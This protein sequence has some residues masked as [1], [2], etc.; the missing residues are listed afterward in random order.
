[1]TGVA[2]RVDGGLTQSVRSEGP[3]AAYAAAVA[4]SGAYEFSPARAAAAGAAVELIEPGMTVGLGSGR[5]VWAVIEAIG[6]RWHGRP[7]ISVVVASEATYAISHAAGIDVVLDG[8]AESIS[9]S[10]EQTRSTP[11][12]AY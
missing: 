6:A 5:A 3:A 2:L 4:V 10:T 7:P 8:G 9:P 11:S 1:M 12:C